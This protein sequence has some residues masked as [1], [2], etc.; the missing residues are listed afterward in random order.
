M[1]TACSG[2]D[3]YTHMYVDFISISTQN[4]GWYNFTVEYGYSVIAWKDDL[5]SHA[6]HSFQKFVALK[7]IV[8]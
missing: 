4:Q 5:P 7:G 3:I 6:E 8:N 1:T 2:A